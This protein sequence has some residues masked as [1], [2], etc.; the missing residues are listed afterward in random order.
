MLEHEIKL[1]RYKQAL[2]QWEEEYRCYGPKGSIA[3]NFTEITR[4]DIQK[5]RAMIRSL[6]KMQA[7]LNREHEKVRSFVYS[8]SF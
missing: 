6:E 5:L 1:G 2:A 7:A 4:K 3:V 8:S